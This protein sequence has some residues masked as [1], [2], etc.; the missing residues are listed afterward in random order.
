MK[1]AL[2][3]TRAA[4]FS[5][6]YLDVIKEA[7]MAE[8]SGV[9]GCMIIK[10]WGVAIWELMQARLDRQIKAMG[11]ENC[12]FPLLIPIELLSKEAQHVEG[13]AKEVAVVT[14]H[15]LVE[16]NGKLVPDGELESPL[17]IRPTSETIIGEAMARWIRSHRDLPLKLNQWANVMRW[18][19]RP[20]LFLRTSEFLW[21]E[22]HTAHATRE[23]A[24]EETAAMLDLYRTLVEDHMAI[25]VVQGRKSPHERFPGADETY[26]IEAMMQDGRALQAGT[27]HFLG[28]NFAKAAGI[29]FQDRDDELKHV[30]TTSWA[31][32]TRLIGALIMT[33]GDDDGLR[34]P[35]R[36]APA[37]VV[38]VPILRDENARASVLE[39]AARL[40]QRLEA[41]VCFDEKVRVNLD[42]RDDS[43]ANKRWR[44]IKKGVP[45]V[46]E[47]GPR[48]VAAE[49]GLPPTAAHGD[50]RE[51]PRHSGGSVRGVD[52][53]RAGSHGP[54]PSRR[55]GRLPQGEDDHEYRDAGRVEGPFRQERRNGVRHG[56]VVRRRP[57]IE[58]RL[59]EMGV[60]VR[61]LPFEQSDTE[62]ATSSPE[63]RRPWTRFS[64]PGPVESVARGTAC[65]L[66]LSHGHR[67]SYIGIPS[68]ATARRRSRPA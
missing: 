35:M 64:L 51:E 17:V 31:V 53:P 58:A 23:E 26:T 29:R 22:G 57:E 11:H 7:D 14:H 68:R 49:G 37:H 28:Q 63:T 21:Q 38:I 42:L 12:Y 1:N 43:P 45:I 40:K 52:I 19:M 66:P 61:C 33:H 25:P 27:S 15:R 24:L 13:F 46:V 36:M 9:R 56:K 16:K 30:F 47:I 20:R 41:A 50:P 8:H 18:E 4:N 44:Y 54:R 67:R 59:A 62:G 5:D 48:D 65:E 10:P 3:T 60:S 34:L 2:A 6:W 39:F 32:T 55:R